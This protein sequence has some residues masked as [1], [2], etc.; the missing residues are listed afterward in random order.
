MLN[1]CI[2]CVHLAVCLHGLVCLKI[3]YL[4]RTT[5]PLKN[6]HVTGIFLSHFVSNHQSQTDLIFLAFLQSF[7]LYLSSESY[8]AVTVELPEPDG[9]IYFAVMLTPTEI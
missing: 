1:G 7:L 9:K 2:T 5:V 3:A 4:R 8:F 6:A